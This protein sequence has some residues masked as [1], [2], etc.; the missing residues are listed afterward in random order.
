MSSTT[1]V[2]LKPGTTN[3]RTIV[4]VTITPSIAEPVP[5]SVVSFPPLTGV[6]ID[7]ENACTHG[8]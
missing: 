5:N 6:F 4:T 3:Y 2:L 1:I 8:S 7:V